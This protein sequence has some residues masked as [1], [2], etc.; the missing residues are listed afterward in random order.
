M[1][2]EL[3]SQGK[4]EE[5]RIR[6]LKE[7]DG[8]E[9]LFCFKASLRGAERKRKLKAEFDAL[10]SSGLTKVED[11]FE[12][13]DQSFL[14]NNFKLPRRKLCPAACQLIP[15]MSNTYLITEIIESTNA[16]DELSEFF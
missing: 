9:P 8:Q 4:K 6:N 11:E 3:E 2:K 10:L 1:N 16:S 14:S 13:Y 7:R 12:C 5:E 15:L